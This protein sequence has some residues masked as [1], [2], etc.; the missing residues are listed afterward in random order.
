MTLPSAD[1]TDGG[2]QVRIADDVLDTVR[3]VEGLSPSPE[4]AESWFEVILISASCY[5][6]LRPF[7][8]AADALVIELDLDARANLAA[9]RQTLDDLLAPY[10]AADAAETDPVQP[11]VWAD[12]P[13]SAA[14]LP[15]RPGAGSGDGA[16][17]NPDG[18][19]DE[20]ILNKVAAALRTMH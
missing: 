18:P 17:S 11:T 13:A 19:V 6:I 8:A 10:R 12:H 9:A 20:R 7:G 1:A 5:R 14:A 2:G 16:R 15:R 4:D 3:A